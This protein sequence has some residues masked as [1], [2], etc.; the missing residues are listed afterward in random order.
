MNIL[1]MLIFI[2]VTFDSLILFK[3]FGNIKIIHLIIPLAYLSLIF[4]NSSFKISRKYYLYLLILL[5]YMLFGVSRSPLF[6]SSFTLFI[7]VLFNVLIF[8]AVLE[9][10]NKTPNKR[11]INI[12]KVGLYIVIIII[13]AETIGSIIGVYEPL[14]KGIEGWFLL[15]RPSGFFKDPGW[16]A[17]WIVPLGMFLLLL[18]KNYYKTNVYIIYLSLILITIINQSRI[19]FFFLIL[20]YIVVKHKSVNYIKISII[21]ILIIVILGYLVIHFNISD[22]LIKDIINLKNNQ[23]VIVSSILVRE[24]QIANK[25]MFGMG[26]GSLPYINKFYNW[27][28]FSK[29]INVFPVQVYYDFGYIGLIFIIIMLIIAYNS[30][31]L[32][33]SKYIFLQL[34][35]I[36]FFHMAMYKQFFWVLLALLF[37]YDNKYCK[38][39]YKKNNRE[40]RNGKT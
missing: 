23:R 36:N 19:G 2:S 40:V 37:F 24:L 5:L 8:I 38:K 31:K 34:I 26:F 20:N 21:G 14:K 16:V 18:G 32:K 22:R 4:S 10:L 29:T 13:F 15:G 1:L 30:L 33:Y 39:Y 35:F 11:I 6:Y 28:N 17:M 3:F 27:I 12:I 25:E 9:M 7:S